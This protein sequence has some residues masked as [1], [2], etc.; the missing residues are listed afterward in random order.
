MT[1]IL[2]EVDRVAEVEEFFP[3]DRGDDAGAVAESLQGADELDPGEPVVVLGATGER[4]LGSGG[5]E[6]HA[7]RAS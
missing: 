4:D 7:R 5:G 1:P 6:Q 3:Q 2:R